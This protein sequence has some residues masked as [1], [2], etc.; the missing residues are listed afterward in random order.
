MDSDWPSLGCV[1]IFQINHCRWGRKRERKVNDWQF[2]FF[3][4]S[5]YQKMG[6]S[7]DLPTDIIS[8]GQAT[9]PICFYH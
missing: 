3:G 6:I 4:K 7:T 5:I 1:L 9:P 8:M 2:D